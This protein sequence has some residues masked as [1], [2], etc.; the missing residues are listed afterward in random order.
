MA[1]FVIF[2][3]SSTD[4]PEEWVKRY[5]LEVVQL[6]L[7][8][9]GKEEDPEALDVHTFYD[10][11]RNGEVAS[12]AAPSPGE[13]T[14][15]MEKYLQNG[16]DILYIGFSEALS[17]TYNNA[18]VAMED[19]SA[20]YPER[21]LF[22]VSSLCASTGHGLLVLLA[23]KQREAG[24]TIEE[25]RDYTVET[26]PHLCHW[27]T[28]DDLM[29]LKRGGRISATTALM[30]TMLGIKPVLHVDDLGRLINVSKTRGRKASVAALFDKVKT[31]AIE[32]S[33]QLMA[34][35]HGDCIEDA[36]GLAERLKTELS[37]PEVIISPTGAVIGAHSGPGTLAVFFLGTGR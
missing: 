34:I 35:C 16:Q 14:E 5:E 12:T 11:L 24:K 13:Y 9:S 2:T 6:H 10:R 20:R 32:P 15:R 1:S 7:T 31:T 27:F 28:V 30:G 17:A 8:V 19:L 26:V 3:D 22:A 4:L 25:V 21:K 29:F 36:K 33:T 23:A 37:V 18:K